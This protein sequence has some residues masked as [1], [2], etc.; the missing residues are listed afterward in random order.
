MPRIPVDNVRV[1]PHGKYKSIR[2]SSA[3][4]S[5]GV[6]PYPCS[7]P[8]VDLAAPKGTPVYAPESGIVTEV[9]RGDTKPWTGYDPA[10]VTMR[11]DSGYS[12][13]LAHLDPEVITRWGEAQLFG[14][15][16]KMY[17][18]AK[19][20]TEGQLLGYVANN[21]T[22][23]EVREGAARDRKRVNPAEWWWYRSPDTPA[24]QKQALMEAMAS[25]ITDTEEGGGGGLFLLLLLWAGSK[26]R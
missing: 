21:H 8:G 11:G 2:R 5:C 9:A 15:E 26:S 1:T 10:L 13:L 6:A 18:L 4:G 20:V 12:H 22:H 16:P 14:S 7:H 19:R 23:W 24:E 3:D 17:P 25:T